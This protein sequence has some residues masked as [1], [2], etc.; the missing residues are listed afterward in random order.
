MKLS[1]EE[2]IRF[3]DL[4]YSKAG[5]FFEPKKIYF[6]KKRLATRMSLLSI[7][8][9]GEY[10]S[11]LK[12]QDKTGSELQEL[13][14]IMTTNET[15]FFREKNQ[16][17]AFC[18]Y[19]LVEMMKKR[20]TA[21]RKRLKIWS[22]GCSAGAEA[23]TIAIMLREKIPEYRSWIIDIIGSDI[24]TVILNTA[25]EG[26]YD[27]RAVRHVSAELLKKY[28]TPEGDHFRITNDIR[29]SVR[30]QHLN[31]F[32][33]NRMRTIRNIDFL[34]CRNVLIYFDDNSRKA[35]VANFYDSL[36]PGG[37]IFLGHSESVTRINSAFKIRRTPKILVHQKPT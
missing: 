6:V 27:K 34:F 18:N 32:D 36:N 33:S 14:N 13:L 25:K 8:E 29:Q 28:F 1:V 24:D 10:F 22:A 31:L 15:Y 37:F 19:C 16:L 9:T 2:F 5:I 12:Y 3:R 35:V 23:Y 26:L 17:E 30:F 11:L 20:K 7:E 21:G 4:I